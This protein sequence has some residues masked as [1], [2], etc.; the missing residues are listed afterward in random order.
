[1]HGAIFEGSGASGAFN[2]RMRLINTDSNDF[3]SMAARQGDFINSSPQEI[4][5]RG[6]QGLVQDGFRR[7]GFY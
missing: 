5:A 7:Q 3:D 1:M 6:L 4:K 2:F